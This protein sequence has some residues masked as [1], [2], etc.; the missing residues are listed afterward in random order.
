MVRTNISPNDPPEEHPT[1]GLIGMG[2][3]GAMYAMQLSKA[4]W[5]KYRYSLINISSS[6]LLYIWPLESASV[7]FPTNL[8]P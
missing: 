1:I 6:H 8:T 4:G 3:M 5:K 7:T 2:A